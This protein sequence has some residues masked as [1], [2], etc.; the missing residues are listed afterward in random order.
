MANLPPHLLKPPP[1][2]PPPAG[3]VVGREPEDDFSAEA[4]RAMFADLESGMERGNREDLVPSGRG[5]H[6][7]GLTY[8]RG[9]DPATWAAPAS[10]RSTG[11]N[12]RR[13]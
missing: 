8:P 3:S 10:E 1:A 6:R 9:A 13:H 12:D 4:I 5:E 2:S 7:G 11:D